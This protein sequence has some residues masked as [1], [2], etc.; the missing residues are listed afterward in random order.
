MKLTNK[1][2]IIEGTLEF[3]YKGYTVSVDF[4][5]DTN[6]VAEVT[7]NNLCLDAPYMTDDKGDY[8]KTMESILQWIDMD[9]ELK[10]EEEKDA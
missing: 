5:K 8:I 6:I 4:H 7:Y 9:I 1:H 3:K 10:E 2:C